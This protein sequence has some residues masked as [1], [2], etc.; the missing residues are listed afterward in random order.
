MGSLNA[1]AHNM[2]ECAAIADAFVHTLNFG[3]NPQP[4]PPLGANGQFPMT[5]GPMPVAH[6]DGK[7]RKARGDDNEVK[8]RA[9]KIKDP[10]APKRPASSYILF[11]NDVRSELRKKNPEMRNNELLSHI[12]K[13]WA[14]MPQE[15]K[16][17]SA[18]SS[19]FA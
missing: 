8:K 4:F 17:V 16:E 11:Q 7:K 18:M 3:A 1:L 5:M 14:E 12:A 10:N 2:R 19:R 15:Q 9:K 13:L 6:D